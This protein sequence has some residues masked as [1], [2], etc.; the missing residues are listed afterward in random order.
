MDDAHQGS[1]PAPPIRTDEVVLA[2]RNPYVTVYDDRVTFADGGR[3]R[4]LR[5]VEKEGEPGV[6]ALAMCAGRIALVKVYRYPI[7]AWEWA[8]PRGFAHGADPAVSV[9]RELDEELGAPP[10][11]SEPL[12][13][14][15]P[16]SGLLAGLVHVFV[17]RYGREVSAPKDR[18]EVA[19][20][21]W[22]TPST[23]LSSQRVF[24]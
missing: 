6:V 19:E 11:S 17:A 3:G 18:R 8:V 22:E 9:R 10:E 21:R 13:V 7:G 14:L 16:N 2:F 12:V 15:H 5:I 1:G 23:M 24:Q 4:H 20:V